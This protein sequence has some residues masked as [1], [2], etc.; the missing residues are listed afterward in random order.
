VLA[1]AGPVNGSTVAAVFTTSFSE[2]GDAELLLLPPDAAERASLSSFTHTPNLD[3]HFASAVFLFSDGTRKE[4]LDRVATAAQ[5]LAPA[6]VSEL[7][8]VANP[9]LPAAESV[10]E[11]SI[12]QSL[13]D[14]HRASSG[15]FYGF[16]GG[17]QLGTFEISY[18]PTDF[19][20]VTIG[21]I[22]RPESGGDGF[23]LWSSFRPR[24]EPAFVPESPRTHRYALDS[25]IS[26]NLL[27]TVNAGFDYRA[28]STDGRVITLDISPDLAVDSATLDG[29]PMEVF[30]NCAAKGGAVRSS[31]LLLVA[32]VSLAAGS[33]HA[34]TVR[35]HGSV[36]RKAEHGYF[37][38]DRTSWYP[39]SGVTLA[40]FD[41]RFRCP[42]GMHLIATGEPVSDE[43]SE[44][45]RSVHTKTA[46]PE[47]LAGFNIGDYA[48]VSLERPP[49]TIECYF[50]KSLSR[51][52]DTQ[53]PR[54]AA[55]ILEAYSRE[56]SQLPIHRLAISPIT[57][58]FGQGFPGLVYLSAVTYVAEQNRPTELRNP[59]LDS[60]FSD[61]LLP[62]EIAHQWWGNLVRSANYR[63][64]WML[65]AMASDAALE[66][67]TQV[68]GLRAVDPVLDRYRD[69]L[70]HPVNGKRL[71]SSGPIDF[72]DRLVS[73]GGLSTWHTIT[74]EKGAWILHMLRARIGDNAF[75]QL[76]TRLLQKFTSK[77][78]TNEDLRVLASAFVPRNQLD[79][80]LKGFF[81]TW[82][83]GTGIPGLK[84]MRQGRDADLRVSGVTDDFIVDIPLSCRARGGGQRDL[85]VHAVSGSNSVHFADDVTACSLPPKDTFLY[86]Q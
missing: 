36:I 17:Q 18:R 46:V 86:V 62:H 83:Y 51:V 81:D 9:L 26:A 43:V 44:G 57:G 28:A 70:V 54:E 30:Q 52:A 38:D 58:F 2:A 13:L 41:L 34:V 74:Y 12:V 72:G 7:E 20:P 5:P 6:Q 69:D 23:Q 65:E 85:W 3:E 75:R 82:I 47:G 53:L 50:E 66:Y 16:I 61:L 39:I 1:F 45:M 31:T 4:I 24:R 22:V 60:F 68:K 63:S 42:A 71:E 55:R 32:P 33:T 49:Y 19:E 27:L 14:A 8:R 80:D 56:W 64:A 35:Y 59:R 84:L 73:E 78:V 29:L 10:F 77:P 40:H 11:L 15:F 21:R 25:T 79:R 37:V 67:L 48:V 76:Q